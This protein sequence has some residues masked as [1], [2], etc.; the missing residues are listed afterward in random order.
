MLIMRYMA[1][2][3]GFWSWLHLI[4]LI[5]I[6]LKQV[7]IYDQEYCGNVRKTEASV[8]K[9]KISIQ[10]RQANR[11]IPKSV[12]PKRL[13]LILKNRHFL[14]TTFMCIK[15]FNKSDLVVKPYVL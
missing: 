14:D 12:G 13:P 3:Y 2:T 7:H 6:F 15:A 1:P 11:S 9:S 4:K 8:D 10:P 5:L